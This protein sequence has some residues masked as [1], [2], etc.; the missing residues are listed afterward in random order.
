M[1]EFSPKM[2]QGKG[3]GD[4][5]HPM[6]IIF[7]SDMYDRNMYTAAVKYVGYQYIIY[8]SIIATHSA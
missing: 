3:G 1:S 7:C 2:R 4:E 8:S 6:D 5:Q